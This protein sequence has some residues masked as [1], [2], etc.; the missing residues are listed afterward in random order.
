[1]LN[2]KFEVFDASS[3]LS[4]S[5]FVVKGSFGQVSSRFDISSDHRFLCVGDNDGVVHIVSL[6]STKVQY[7]AAK[8]LSTQC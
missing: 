2:G 4:T 3:L 5:T 8:I 6:A 1:M 7:E